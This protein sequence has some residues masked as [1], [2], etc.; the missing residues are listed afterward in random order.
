M[1]PWVRGS[2]ACAGTGECRN[3]PVRVRGP[4]LSPSCRRRADSHSDEGG[5]SSETLRF[6]CPKC[7]RLSIVGRSATCRMVGPS[8]RVSSETLRRPHRL[9]MVN[10][11]SE[12]VANRTTYYQRACKDF[13]T[14]QALPLSARRAHITKHPAP[15]QQSFKSIALQ[16]LQVHRD[17][18]N[19]NTRHNM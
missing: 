19:K 11:Y 14:H 16:V 1:G 13:E 10:T 6:P 18:C 3:A 9:H 2:A 12:S 15:L 8:G 7:R 17:S 4:S 5:R